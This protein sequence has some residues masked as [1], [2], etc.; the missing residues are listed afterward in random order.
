[1]DTGNKDTSVRF[2]DQSRVSKQKSN[3]KRK[4]EK[5]KTDLEKPCFLGKKFKWAK[6]QDIRIF[7]PPLKKDRTYASWLWSG[8][9]VHPK[10]PWAGGRKQALVRSCVVAAS[11]KAS[12]SPP[13]LSSITG[14]KESQNNSENSNNLASFLYLSP[15]FVTLLTIIQ[16]PLYNP[17][18]NQHD[19]QQVVERHD[20]GTHGSSFFALEYLAP[21]WTHGFR[22]VTRTFKS[23]HASLCEENLRLD[24]CPLKTP[25]NPKGSRCP[26]DTH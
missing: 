8:S 18:T 11:P 5:K 19:W 23:S 13:P 26:E 3:K 9:R 17:M 21:R 15:D 4:K 2:M 22:T 12:W 6:P 1:M 24:L 25:L 16:T 7:C 14:L 10:A 20:T